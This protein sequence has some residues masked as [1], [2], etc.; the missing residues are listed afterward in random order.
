MLPSVI[1]ATRDGSPRC[2]RGELN[3]VVFGAQ[4]GER[5]GVRLPALGDQVTQFVEIFLVSGRRGNQEHPTGRRTGVSKCVRGA[6]R[7]EYASSRPATNSSFAAAQI[8]LPL[9][10]VEN[11]FNLDGNARRC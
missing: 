9:Q 11:L 5:L 10:N 3:R 2:Q 8:E 7:D 6:G 1:D 4:I